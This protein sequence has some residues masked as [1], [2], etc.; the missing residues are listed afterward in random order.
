MKASIEYAQE[1][2]RK[3]ATLTKLGCEL[4]LLLIMLWPM[5]DGRAVLEKEKRLGSG[6]R[7]QK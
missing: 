2:G 3:G 1:L 5:G 6:D 7:S 4:E